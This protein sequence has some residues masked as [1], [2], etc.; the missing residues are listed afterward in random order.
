[1]AGT[2]DQHMIEA[3]KITIS[4]QKD[5]IN[6][7]KAEVERLKTAQIYIG[8]PAPSYPGLQGTPPWPLGQPI[9][10]PNQTTP[11]LIVTSTGDVPGHISGRTITP[12]IGDTVTTSSSCKIEDIG[13][14]AIE[15][16]NA[17]N[18]VLG[19]T[20]TTEQSEENMKN[21]RNEVFGGVDHSNWSGKVKF[22]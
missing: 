1:M 13:K 6:H 19:G 3:L 17:Q 11:P 5:L 21:I 14:N 15:T 8:S 20:V 16:I 10:C 2:P 12:L 22:K 4:V 18:E 9:Y 7:L